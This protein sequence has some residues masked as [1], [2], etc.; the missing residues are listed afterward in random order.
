[1]FDFLR[2][3]N[4][5]IKIVELQYKI[6]ALKRN[7]E[8]NDKLINDIHNKT[9]NLNFKPN[10]NC[11][12]R[13]FLNKFLKKKKLNI[14]FIS[15]N[16]EVYF[17]YI[18]YDNK[19]YFNI[20]DKSYTFKEKDFYVFRNKPILFIYENQPLPL[21]FEN[22]SELNSEILKSIIESKFIS[23]ILSEKNS[24]FGLGLNKDMFI[25]II[26]ILS[27][28]FLFSQGFFNDIFSH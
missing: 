22:N 4:K 14:V 1:M 11:K 7:I 15:D 18:F 25:L 17:K 24:L 28:L 27:L 9:L 19:N 6:K 26:I 21:L 8:K 3:N 16:K 10:F 2:K 12:L 23:E 13:L 20:R 5:D